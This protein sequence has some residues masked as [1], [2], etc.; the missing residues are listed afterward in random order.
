MDPVPVGVTTATGVVI[1]VVH[2]PTTGDRLK[3]PNRPRPANTNTS[4]TS[5]KSCP[6][7]SR[8]VEASLPSR[9]GEDGS[10]EG[11]PWRHHSA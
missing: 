2:G 5:E 1:P 7:G 10:F 8:L 3:R 11:D 9:T 4:G 6:R